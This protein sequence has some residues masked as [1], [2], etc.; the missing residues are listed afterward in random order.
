MVPVSAPSLHPD[1]LALLAACRSAPAD[2]V[3]RLV[4]ADWLDE[5]ADAAGLPDAADARDRAALVRVQVELARP[6]CDLGRVAQLRAEEARLLA[7][8]ADRWL[9]DLPARLEQLRRT[10]YGYAAGAS[11]APPAAVFNPRV[12]GSCRFRRGLLGVGLLPTEL[13][14]AEVGA[15]FASPLAAWVEEAGTEISGLNALERLAVSDALRPYLGVRYVLGAPPRPRMGLVT[16]RPEAL[17]PKR[18]KRFVNCS[19]FA[20]V[21]S[22]EIHPGA[23]EAGVLPLLPGAKVGGLRWLTVRA[24]IADAGAAFLAAAPLTNLSALDISGCSIEAGGFRL[25]ANS[26]H[27]RQ[28]VSVT[29]Y[30]NLIGCDGIVAL[31]ASPLAERL[32]VLEIQNAEIGDRGVTALARSPLLDRL[33]GPGLNLSM[34]PISDAGAAALAAS[35]RLEPFTELILRDCRVGD[36]GAAALADSPHVANLAY[37]D[38]W[39]NRVGDAGAR[40]LAASPHLTAVRELSL[41]DNAVT[42]KGATALR[43]RFGDRVKV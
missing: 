11:A 34:N 24:P 21:R 15:W 3:P 22:L 8:N 29:A 5:N 1:L 33:T 14:D 23:V 28:L 10:L 9:G 6:T 18:C 39:H 43:K 31:A 7:R 41:R 36:R 32:T 40:A 13:T 26:P 42:A 17:T 25:I 2:D 20:L 27:L 12:V 30:R 37:L 4:L 35:P 16:P 38:L 19:N